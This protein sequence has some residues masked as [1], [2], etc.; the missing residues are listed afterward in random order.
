M[1]EVLAWIGAALRSSPK[2]NGVVYS[3]PFIQ[4]LDVGSRESDC[5][6]V[7]CTIGFKIELDLGT[8]EFPESNGTCWYNLFRNPIIVKGYPI[9]YRH[10]GDS[11]VEMPIEM[12][13][14]L[15][16]SRKLTDFAGNAVIKSF[17]A[18]LLLTERLAGAAVAMWHLLFNEDGDHISFADPRVHKIIAPHSKSADFAELETSR[19]IVGWC[20]KVQS[21]T[22]MDRPNNRTCST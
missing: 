14:S 8:D 4:D 16:G 11:G 5:T 2:D 15:I 18:M 19:H 6:S 21:F 9:R 7:F 22:G 12:M 10:L 17:S 1:G 13:A 3:V 20:S